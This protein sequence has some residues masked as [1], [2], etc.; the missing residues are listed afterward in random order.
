MTH[1][2]SHSNKKGYK[3]EKQK[4]YVIKNNAPH[5]CISNQSTKKKPNPASS[6][7]K[8][9]SAKV[10]NLQERRQAKNIVMEKRVQS[11]SKIRK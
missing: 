1:P 5:K 9:Q 4:L 8:K 3:S 7:T 6:T 2:K 10:I 11:Y